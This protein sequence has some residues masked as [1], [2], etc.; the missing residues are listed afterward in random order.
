MVRR[1]LLSLLTV[2]C[3]VLLPSQHPLRAD[4]I[5][6]MD[7]GV[8]QD[9][10]GKVKVIVA[11]KQ[12][13]EGIFVLSGASV[14][15]QLFNIEQTPPAGTN[16]LFIR[17]ESSAQPPVYSEVVINERTYK[18]SG[19]L[20]I[21]IDKD[22]TVGIDNNNPYLTIVTEHDGHAPAVLGFS[23]LNE[24][25]RGTGVA[26][27]ILAANQLNS[28]AAKVIRPYNLKDGQIFLGDQSIG[29]GRLGILVRPEN[30]CLKPAATVLNQTQLA[31]I[32]QAKSDQERAKLLEQFL[33]ESKKSAPLK[34]FLVLK[35][36]SARVIL[37]DIRDQNVFSLSALSSSNAQQKVCVLAPLPLS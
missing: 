5:Q 4:W 2:F 20:T 30:E 15:V 28:E 22:T 18:I 37:L 33:K 11:S 9:S 16:H 12:G 35:A 32:R 14:P 3:A 26:S 23:G 31:T 7:G 25:V 36:E 17:F 34:G 27:T 24:V 10:S 8:Y 19:N 21:N 13:S 6:T 1:C 29:S